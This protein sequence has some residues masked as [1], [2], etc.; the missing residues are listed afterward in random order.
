MHVHEST[1]EKL[2]DNSPNFRNVFDF[3]VFILMLD[4]FGF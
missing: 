1:Q 4:F 2:Q 3:G